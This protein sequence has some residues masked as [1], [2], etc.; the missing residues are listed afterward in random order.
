[1]PWLAESET[2]MH[3]PQAGQHLAPG[4]VDADARPDIRCLLIDLPAP[5]LGPVDLLDTDILLFYY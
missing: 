2:G 3:L 4:S 5:N 1:M